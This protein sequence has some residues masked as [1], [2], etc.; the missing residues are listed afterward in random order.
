M[1]LQLFCLK[2]NMHEIC[3]PLFVTVL[4]I[5]YMFTKDRIFPLK[6]YIFIIM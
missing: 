3:K 6:T 2:L 1:L 4:C 5:N